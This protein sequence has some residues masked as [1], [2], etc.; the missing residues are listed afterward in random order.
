[1]TLVGMF[2]SVYVERPTCPHGHPP[3][4]E[5]VQ[6]KLYTDDYSPWC[7]TYKIGDIVVSRYNELVWGCF[8]CQTCE[9]LEYTRW[10]AELQRDP[11]GARQ[12]HT[13][14]GS[15]LIIFKDGA[16]VGAMDM[17]WDHD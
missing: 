3:E 8:G 16:I 9:Q 13:P 10:T 5:E 1:M 7:K 12:K 11:K 15:C 14:F 4:E 2:D 6:F 17:K